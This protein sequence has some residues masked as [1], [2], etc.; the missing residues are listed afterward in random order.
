MCCVN[1]KGKICKYIP[2][3]S[4]I[5]MIFFLQA[6]ELGLLLAD[7][8]WP[9]LLPSAIMVVIFLGL[10]VGYRSQCM[11][12][13]VWVAYFMVATLQFLAMSI[14]L[15]LASVVGAPNK[16]ECNYTQE[17]DQSTRAPNDGMFEGSR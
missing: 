14:V 10:V 12:D 13:T 8:E 2:F 17:S 16:V 15:A 1:R 5:L 3:W 6:A 7:V 4:V 11:R 9:L